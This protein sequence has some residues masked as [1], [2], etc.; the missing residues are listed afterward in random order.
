MSKTTVIN[1]MDAVRTIHD[2]LKPLDPEARARVLQ[3]SMTLLQIGAPALQ[4]VNQQ[5]QSQGSVITHH[6]AGS[7]SLVSV[8]KIDRFV[9]SKKPIDTYQRLAC[10]AYFLE[11]KEEKVDLSVKELKQANSDARQSNI[12]N[13][14]AFLDKATSRH[15]YFSAAGKGKKRL[16]VRGS[17]VVEALPDRAAVKEALAQ[18]PLPKKGGRKPKR[19]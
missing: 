7:S 9:A 11:H 16:S 12:S 18:N 5:S 3:A 17:A 4:T 19:K 13:I 14:S 2:A 8:E 15:G 6:Q 1:D 10:L